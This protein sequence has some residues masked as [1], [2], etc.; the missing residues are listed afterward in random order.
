MRPFV[1]FFLLAGA[2]PALPKPD[3]CRALERH[4]R[5][6][7]A[8]GCFRE[9]TQSSNVFLRA[10]GYYGL[11]AWAQANN[12]FR[13]AH[14]QT[15]DNPDLKVRWGR[16]LI[17]P[18]NNNKQ[19][20]AALFGE[21]LELNK[22]H[23][24]ALLG[25]AL[26]ASDGFDSKAIEFVNRALEADPKLVEAQEL[27]ASLMLEDSNPARAGEEADK[28]LK[29]DPEALDAMAVRAA[30]EILADRPGDDWLGRIYKINPS[31]GEGHALIAHHLVLNRRYDEG[32][33]HYRKAVELDPEHWHARSQL[34][35]NLMRMGK[36][37]EA[38]QH[39]EASFENGF[40]EAATVNSIRLL[41]SF[42]K[43]FASF[44]LPHSVLKLDKKE[45][46][47][48]RLYFEEELERAI[49]TYEKKY[50]MKLDGPVRL[51]V[52]PNHE[53]FAVRTAGMPGLGILGVTFGMVVAMDSPS[54]RKPGTFHW[55][56]TLWHELSH[57]FVLSAT[58]HR[59]PRWFTEGVA[60]HE[61]TATHA[62]WGDRLTPDIIL[63]IKDKKLLPVAELDR[64]FIRPA[65]PSQVIVSYFQ[66]GRICDFIV[67]SWSYDKLLEMMHAFGRRQST[68][69][70]IENVLGLRAE[71]FDKRFLAWLDKSVKTTV[72]GFEEWRKTMRALAVAWKDKKYDEMLKEGDQAL[73]LY[74]EYVENGNAYEALADAAAEKG[75][76]ARARKILENY[77]TIGGR[78]PES[79]KKLATWQEE[80]GDKRAAAATLAKLNF[81]YPVKDDALHRR[82]GQLYLGLGDHTGAI[83]EFRAAAA[84][85]PLDRA[86]TYYDLARAYYAARQI[87]K[88][89]EHLFESLEAA[90]GYRPA[91]KLL[92]ELNAQKEKR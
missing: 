89:E 47:I 48:L 11:R 10:E 53:D 58:H 25:M 2:L 46:D 42:Q 18:F 63:A 40:R 31:Y 50:K 19:D 35:I 30:V 29:L 13:A 4:G 66:A 21:A 85:K 45:A 39:L 75:D 20:G 43:N 28:A 76:K 15:P 61:E 87:D 81:I 92:L 71:E 91:Q 54:G 69:E 24:G 33:Q 8:R 83:R 74:P 51:E 67:G 6:A 27:L 59:V 12:E 23:P 84:E 73:R 26:V 70:V 14:A 80:A 16:L 79:L 32:I 34:G 68:P 56:S 62:D 5:R 52:F 37:Q 72:S 65:Y 3:E 1:S 77:A 7:D 60:V 36:E 64:G 86:A 82:L 57:V 9:L 17:E 38:R 22:K 88:A 44:E 78:S 49:A 55:A 41:E 90:P